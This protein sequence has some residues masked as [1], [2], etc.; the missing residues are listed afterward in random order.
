MNRREFIQGAALTMT[1]PLINGCS[2]LSPSRNSHLYK[3]VQLHSVREQ[4]STN[5]NNTFA[6][7]ANIG[8]QHVEWADITTLASQHA[9][10]QANGLEVTSVHAMSPFLF[11][12]RESI[13]HH[14]IKVPVALNSSQKV[15]EL[16]AR[17][18][19][20]NLVFPYLFVEER[21]SLDQYKWLIEQ[22]NLLGGQAKQ[23]G[24]TVS[25]HNHEFE[26][27]AIDG[28]LPFDLLVR[29]LEQV[30][31]ELDVFWLQYAGVDPAKM[32]EQLGARCRL[33]HLK[34]LA[35]N[36]VMPT[37]VAANDFKPLGQGSIDFSSV[38]AAAKS[39]GV[40][41][42]FVEQDHATAPML[43][44]LRQSFNYLQTQ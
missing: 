43:E 10:A 44:Q 34:D 42:A 13:A 30:A 6:A 25:Y 22:L 35:P 36:I 9:V 38:L 29:D 39:V 14:G 3:G 11:G 27:N 7:L 26:F 37:Q 32:I 8:Y 12:E 17:H 31:F 23:F 4:L 16:L 2:L 41:H 18:Q 33:L 24:I 15:L 1:L 40:Q 21:Q 19:I 28:Q 20:K 5:P